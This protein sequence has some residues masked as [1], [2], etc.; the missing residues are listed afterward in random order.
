MLTAL[1]HRHRNRPRYRNDTLQAE[2]EVCNPP[3]PQDRPWSPRSRYG[4]VAEQ[5]LYDKRL[6]N[7]RASQWTSVII[8]DSLFAKIITTYLTWDHPPC[9]LF[10]EDMFIRDL[11]EGNATYCSRLLVNAI[12]AYGCVGFFPHCSG[13]LLTTNAAKSCRH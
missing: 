6:H 9:R 10:D 8:E 3:G 5:Q 2:G 7:V 13:P 1:S 12:L 4:S 11:V